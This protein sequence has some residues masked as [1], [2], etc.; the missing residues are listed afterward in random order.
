MPLKLDIAEPPPSTAPRDQGENQGKDLPA[1][2]TPALTEIQKPPQEESAQSKVPSFL[3]P[4]LMVKFPD[5]N[6]SCAFHSVEI[7]RASQENK[8]SYPS[9]VP[10][11]NKHP[12]GKIAFYRHHMGDENLIDLIEVALNQRCQQ[13]WKQA[14]TLA[15]SPEDIETLFCA[16]FYE[17]RQRE[18]VTSAGLKKKAEE[19]MKEFMAEKK[20]NGLSQKAIELNGLAKEYLKKAIDKTQE[21]MLKNLES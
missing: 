16:V 5:T 1:E 12:E 18:A 4:E 2:P 6:Q 15:Q 17:G 14:A 7:L 19:Y 13:I 3:G 21:E 9:P 11:A 10:E 8:W 20:K